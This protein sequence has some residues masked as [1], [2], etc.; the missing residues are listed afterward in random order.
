[1]S[2]LR[3]TPRAQ[4][5]PAPAPGSPDWQRIARAI[6]AGLDDAT[7]ARATRLARAHVALI[8]ARIAPPAAVIP[9]PDLRRPAERYADALRVLIAHEGD[10]YERW[11]LR[12]RWLAARLAVWRYAQAGE[13]LAAGD[14]ARAVGLDTAARQAERV[15]ARS[16]LEVQS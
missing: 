10:E 15:A 5:R 13:A 11:L 16:I 4:S 1:M 7:A 12:R 2:S 9:A 14:L 8:R 6:A 3:L